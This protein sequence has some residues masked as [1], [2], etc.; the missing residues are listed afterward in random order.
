MRIIVVQVAEVTVNKVEVCRNQK[1]KVG[2][3][4]KV[5]LMPIYLFR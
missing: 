5:P 3:A 1:G 2:Y 4:S